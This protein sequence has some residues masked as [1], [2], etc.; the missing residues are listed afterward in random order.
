MCV[1]ILRNEIE[2]PFDCSLPLEIQ[3]ADATEVRVNYQPNDAEVEKFLQE[4]DRCSKSGSDLKMNLKIEY[5]NF[6]AGFKVKK[7]LRKALS[8]ISVNEI[9]KLMVLS[10]VEADKKL[11][12]LSAM[13]LNRES[14]VE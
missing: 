1:K 8:D 10:Q 12:E 3:V 4:V 5:N 13:C 11:Q 7:Q 6:L 9:I 2:F 14:N